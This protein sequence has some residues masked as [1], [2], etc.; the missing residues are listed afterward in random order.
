[1]KLKMTSQEIRDYLNTNLTD[2]KRIALDDLPNVLIVN[3]S[4]SED[5][6]YQLNINSEL[7]D[8]LYAE[9]EEEY[10]DLA[11]IKSDFNLDVSLEN[12]S[13]ETMIN[14]HTIYA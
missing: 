3:E 13:K 6:I 9:D 8:A 14:L 12:N 5:D 7:Y 4:L 1:M 2:M 10:G 11:Q